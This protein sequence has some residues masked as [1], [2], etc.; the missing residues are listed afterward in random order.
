MFNPDLEEDL[1]HFDYRFTGILYMPILNQF[2]L[3][4]SLIFG[5]HITFKRGDASYEELPLGK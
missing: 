5:D 1:I 4:F 2:D 3:I